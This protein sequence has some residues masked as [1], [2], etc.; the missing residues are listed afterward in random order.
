MSTHHTSRQHRQRGM[1]K[2]KAHRRYTLV[3]APDGV[4]VL[5]HHFLDSSYFLN[6]ADIDGFLDPLDNSMGLSYEVRAV[7]DALSTVLEDA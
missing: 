4:R 1:A 3:T 7:S 2:S 6:D 5:G